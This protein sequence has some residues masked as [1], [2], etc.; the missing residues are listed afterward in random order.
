MKPRRD[1]QKKDV[2][3]NSVD[4]T[5]LSCEDKINLDELESM[6]EFDILDLGTFNDT[7]G[8]DPKDIL[9]I[10]I[11]LDYEEEPRVY[12]N[13]TK[14]GWVNQMFFVETIS[15]LDYIHSYNIDEIHIEYLGDSQ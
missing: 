5:G 6:A 14:Y 10:E 3:D 12:S 2:S 1:K 13:I 7:I 15:E 4:D 8:R 11:I 9:Y